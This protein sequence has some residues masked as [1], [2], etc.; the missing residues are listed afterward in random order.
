M[1]NKN[2]TDVNIAALLIVVLFGLWGGFLN[3][4]RYTSHH[5]YLTTLQKIIIFI[6]DIISNI[7]ISIIIFLALTGYGINE[8]LS[9]AIA[10]FIGHAGANGILLIQLLLTKHFNDTKSI[11]E[12]LN[13]EVKDI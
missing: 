9:V 12:V 7:S 1:V 4:V 13:N 6:I 5:K 11:T 3:F 8:V 10:G 2:L